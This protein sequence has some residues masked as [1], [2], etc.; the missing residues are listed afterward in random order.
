M[1]VTRDAPPPRAVEGDVDFSCRTV[2]RQHGA[3]RREMASLASSTPPNSVAPWNGDLANNSTYD[4][5]VSLRYRPLRSP[6]RRRP[7]RRRFHQVRRT[8]AGPASLGRVASSCGNL[9]KGGAGQN[10]ARPRSRTNVLNLDLVA[11][12]P[13]RHIFALL[14]SR[15]APSRNLSVPRACPGSTAPDILSSSSLSDS[16]SDK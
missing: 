15:K 14:H 7:S 10:G 3:A 16:E 9:V 12:A 8:R 6:G 11:A 4:R 13:R 2:A 1:Q 5:S